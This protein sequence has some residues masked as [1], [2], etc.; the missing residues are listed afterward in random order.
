MS[1]VSLVI[2]WG[3]S[4]R[5]EVKHPSGE[6]KNNVVS[7][8]IWKWRATVSLL[9]AYF[10]TVLKFKCCSLYAFFLACV[11]VH[12][13]DYGPKRMWKLRI[14]YTLY[15]FHLVERRNKLYSCVSLDSLRSRCWNKGRRAKGLLGSNIHEETGFG[16]ECCIC[17]NSIWPTKVTDL[18][19][20]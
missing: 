5:S 11:H 6:K 8:K 4:N 12:K 10:A 17:H 7:S 2:S 13:Q 3:E 16:K 19:F 9:K 14:I 15:I 18:T 1:A 20:S